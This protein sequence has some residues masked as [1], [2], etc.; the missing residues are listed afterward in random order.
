MQRLRMEDFKANIKKADASAGGL[1]VWTVL[2]MT[3]LSD[4]TLQKI[5]DRLNAIE[6]GTKS[7]VCMTETR[8][9]FLNKHP[10]D[11]ANP[12]A[13]RIMKITSAIY[14]QWAN[15][16]LKDLEGWVSMWHSVQ[17]GWE[18]VGLNDLLLLRPT[19]RGV[20]RACP[21]SFFHLAFFL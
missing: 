20:T 3:L 14:R 19:D 16:R 10:E 18:D 4:I 9:V 12:L 2:D 17:G 15:T 11:A 7:P 6:E 1:D 8:A 21:P 5:V 13:Y